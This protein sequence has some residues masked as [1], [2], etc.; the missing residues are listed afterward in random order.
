LQAGLLAAFEEL[1]MRTEKLGALTC[2]VENDGWPEELDPSVS[3]PLYRIVQEALNNVVAHAQA[4]QVVIR[5]SADEYR[6]TLSVT[7]NG[8]GLPG[9]AVQAPGMGLRIMRYRSD[10]IG[11]DLQIRPAPQKGTTVI[12]A[13]PR[14][15]TAAG[16]GGAR[17][18]GSGESP[19]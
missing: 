17:E 2:R 19:E 6:L 15:A 9:G 11:A 5:L 1:A 7:D 18:A 13:C 10:L 3:T 8:V 12:C 16:P 4:T 14:P